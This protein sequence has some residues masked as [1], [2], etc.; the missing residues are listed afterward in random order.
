MQLIR[1][2]FNNQLVNAPSGLGRLFFARPSLRVTAPQQ[3]R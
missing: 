2:E 3:K 1:D